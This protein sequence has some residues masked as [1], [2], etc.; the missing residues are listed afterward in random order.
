[1]IL[2]TLIETEIGLKIFYM[3]NVCSETTYFLTS[4]IK[5][6]WKFL[7]AGQSRWQRVIPLHIV[8][9]TQED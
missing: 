5:N 1:M 8:L 6:I 4:L 7:M 3:K 2:K 9:P